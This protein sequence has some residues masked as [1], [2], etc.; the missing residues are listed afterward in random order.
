M[1]FNIEDNCHVP[2]LLILQWEP[3]GCPHSHM[4]DLEVWR[5]SCHMEKALDQWELEAIM[6]NFPLPTPLFSTH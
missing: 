5:S 6:K 3:L 4:S 1:E 2:L